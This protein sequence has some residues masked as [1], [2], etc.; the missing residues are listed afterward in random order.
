MSCTHACQT[1]VPKIADYYSENLYTWCTNCGNYGIHGALKRALVAQKIPSCKAV[2]C[3]DIG[4]NGNGSDKIEG[5]RFHGLHGRIISFAC[6]V[7][8]A[9]PKLTVIA[10]AGD[11]ATFGE[12]IG[13]L[14]HAIR[15]NYNITFMFHNNLNYGLTKGQASPTTKP[16]TGM[17]SSPDGIN[18]EP[19]H[20]MRLVLSLNPTFVARSFSGDVK[21]MDGVI[22]RAMNHR[23]FSFV[24]ILQSCPTYNKQTPHE[25]YQERVFDVK[26]VPGYDPQSK[27]AA[28][29]ISADLEEKIALGV[30]YQNT[31]SL[32]FIENQANR[33]GVTTTLVEEVTPFNVTELAN[34]FR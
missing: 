9:N 33:V 4:C 15:G 18:S 14:I 22:Q 19:V 2:L 11:G 25:W 17:N 12:G 28:T 34:S 30:L 16:G 8:V 6:G 31:E 21:H 1:A 26:N 20:P 10:S 32:S 3:F 7:A 24:E 23:G 5:Y 29:A 13:H 27:S